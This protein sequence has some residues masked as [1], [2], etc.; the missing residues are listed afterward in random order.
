MVEGGGTSRWRLPFSWPPADVFLL[1]LLKNERRSLSRAGLAPGWVALGE[2]FPPRGSERTSARGGAL[3]CPPGSS[4]LRAAG[5]SVGR[6]PLPSGSKP[7]RGGSSGPEGGFVGYRRGGRWA[8][9]PLQAHP[10]LMILRSYL[11]R[12]VKMYSGCCKR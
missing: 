11:L 12:I 3:L 6:T 1:R 9:L 4:S 8:G 2:G 10:C 5:M 7:V